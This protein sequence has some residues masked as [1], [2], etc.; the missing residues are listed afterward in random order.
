MSSG[1]LRI[2][3]GGLFSALDQKCADFQKRKND[4]PILQRY[5]RITAEEWASEDCRLDGMAG[6]VLERAISNHQKAT[7]LVLSH[8]AEARL[9]SDFF[10]QVHATM[11]SG[12]SV[13]AGVFRVGEIAP[14]SIN[15]APSD[16]EAI[17]TA[18]GYLIEWTAAE[19][20]SELHPVQ[21]MALALVRLLDIYPFTEGT[22]RTC[23]VLANYYLTR[24]G[25]PPAIFR[26]TDAVDYAAALEVAF[27]MD[28]SRLTDLI[29]RAV[30]RSIDDCLKDSVV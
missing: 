16:P 28:T 6:D 17:E 5:H 22:H 9:E 19:S 26:R 20:F 24:A 12:L 3:R 14:L 21:Q 4:S 1:E 29:A 18:L 2:F 15:H 23:R 11:M 13:E 8:P 25:L 27:T 7:T 30:S 10:K